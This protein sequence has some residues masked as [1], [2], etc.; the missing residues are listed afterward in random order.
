M[1]CGSRGMCM[2]W[3]TTGH[4][5]V[6]F[7]TRQR[8]GL[9]PQTSQARVRE[10]SSEYCEMSVCRRLCHPL[11]PCS[12][13]NP[14]TYLS[15]NAQVVTTWPRLQL[16][17][18]NKRSTIMAIVMAALSGQ[19]PRGL[20]CQDGLQVCMHRGASNHMLL[21]HTTLQHQPQSMTCRQ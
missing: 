13:C 8:C 17:G 9:W 15:T 4:T 1:S 14:N 6:S 3:S 16:S 19:E 12:P 2:R 11:I 21:L 5:H 20:C 10:C 18:V 7:S